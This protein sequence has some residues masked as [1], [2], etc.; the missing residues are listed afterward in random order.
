MR[1]RIFKTKQ[2]QKLE[3]LTRENVRS[4]WLCNFQLVFRFELD[5]VKTSNE[6]VCM[7]EG[8]QSRTF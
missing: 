3:M 2:K 6:N 4:S 8:F 5:A 1:R 7:D